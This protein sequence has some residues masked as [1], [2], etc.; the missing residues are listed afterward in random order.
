[1]KDKF[2]DMKGFDNMK[3]VLGDDFKKL[4]T[5]AMMGKAMKD[6]AKP[7]HQAMKRNA[8]KRKVARKAAGKSGKL[9]RINTLA[10]EIK[11]KKIGKRRPFV[12]VGATIK[13][14]HAI[15]VERGT[16]PHAIAPKK[17]GGVLMFQPT[18]LKLG[19]SKGDFVLKERKAGGLLFTQKVRHPG[20][21]PKP[22][23]RPAFDAH[24]AKWVKQTGVNLWKAARKKFPKLRAKIER[25]HA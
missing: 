22:F 4:I 12:L 14:P 15:L 11:I 6:A 25:R 21:R 19:K 20:S 1:M 16:S 3:K 7:M 23:I 17:A 2:L 13:A 24:K 5:P 8:P 10:R 18:V 9:R